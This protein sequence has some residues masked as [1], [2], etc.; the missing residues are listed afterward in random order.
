MALEHSSNHDQHSR[1]RQRDR[2]SEHWRK[3]Q[4]KRRHHIRNDLHHWSRSQ[5]V[6]LGRWSKISADASCTDALGA[7]TESLYEGKLELDGNLQ[8]TNG[9]FPICAVVAVEISKPRPC[10]LLHPGFEPSSYA[11]KCSHNVVTRPGSV[12]KGPVPSSLMSPIPHLC[13]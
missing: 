4:A 7:D 8:Y 1:T 10:W 13:A 12:V 9:G 2:G 6:L 5:R 11:L 3:S